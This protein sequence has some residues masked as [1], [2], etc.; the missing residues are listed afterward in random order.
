MKKA[1]KDVRGMTM[2][3][4]TTG[5]GAKVISGAGGDASALSSMSSMYPTLGTIS[6]AGMTLRAMKKLKV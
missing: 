4:V 3:G 2:L 5:V 6:G 1:L